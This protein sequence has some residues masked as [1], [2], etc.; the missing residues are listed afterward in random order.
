LKVGGNRGVSSPTRFFE[1]PGVSPGALLYTEAFFR[2]LKKEFFRPNSF[3]DL[4]EV[5][6]QMGGFLFEYNHLRRH[7]GLTYMAPSDK[8]LRVTELVR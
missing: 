1:A 8:L 4:A 2:I 7:G 3:R 6:E 5:K